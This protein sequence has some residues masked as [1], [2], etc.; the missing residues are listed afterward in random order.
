[1]QAKVSPTAGEWNEPALSLVSLC[2]K[3]AIA[4]SCGD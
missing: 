2:L 1:M 4:A 3:A